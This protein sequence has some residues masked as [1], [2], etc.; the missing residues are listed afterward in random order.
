MLHVLV[1]ICSCTLSIQQVTN[2][3]YEILS[4]GEEIQL[5]L[6]DYFQFA[7]E[8]KINEDKSSPNY[9]EIF[10][11]YKNNE[12]YRQI[13][14]QAMEFQYGNKT[15]KLSDYSYYST[16]AFYNQPLKLFLLDNNFILMYVYN[17]QHDEY[18]D[19]NQVLGLNLT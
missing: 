8:S 17:D 13:N 2:L 14:I 18:G 7:N 4:E 10:D 11:V 15:I 5:N 12:P 3:S 19:K 16:K 1:L 6:Q 9:K